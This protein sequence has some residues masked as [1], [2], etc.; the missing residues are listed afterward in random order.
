MDDSNFWDRTE[1]PD[2]NIYEGIKTSLKK[3]EQ[4]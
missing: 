1:M 3:Q 4:E 2:G